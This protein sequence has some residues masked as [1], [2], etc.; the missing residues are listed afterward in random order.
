MFNVHGTVSNLPGC[1]SKRKIY[2]RSNGRT[3][4]GWRTSRETQAEVKK[5]RSQISDKFL[6][7]AD[8]EF[9][10]L[11]HHQEGRSHGLFSYISI[12][13]ET[14]LLLLLKENWVWF[15]WG[16]VSA[17]R[18][19]DSTQCKKHTLFCSQ[20]MQAAQSQ[21]RN[22]VKWEITVLKPTNT[23]PPHTKIC[24]NHPYVLFWMLHRLIG[25]WLGEVCL[26]LGSTA[27]DICI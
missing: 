16:T 17:K 3:V 5:V 25:S 21:D 24:S 1:D 13:Q 20:H 18:V 19:Q 9:E 4:K 26:I 8:P 15:R 23:L 11:N 27:F 7:R 2:P 14:T 22:I 10:Y 6:V 12:E